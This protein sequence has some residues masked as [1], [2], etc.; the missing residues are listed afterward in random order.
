ML[1]LADNKQ[2]Q[3]M[4]PFTFKLLITLIISGGCSLITAQESEFL[5]GKVL[6]QKTGEPVVFATVRILGKAKG[7]VTNMDGS[8]RLPLTYRAAGESIQIS[9][10]GYVKKEFELQKLSPQDINII[11]LDHGVFSLTE[12]VVRAKRKRR[13]SA[14]AIVRRAIE[15]IPDNYPITKFATKG[16]YRDY[17]LDSLGYL[18]LNEA[19]LQVFDYGFNEIDSATTKIR[20]YDYDENMNFRRDTLADDSYNYKD[21]RKIIDNAYLESHG[22]NEFTILRVHD[23]IRNYRINSFDFIN[24]MQYGDVLKNHS[25]KKLT[26]TYLDGEPLYTI[27]F[28]KVIS[29]YTA[30]GILYISKNDFAI[31]KLEYAVYDDNKRDDGEALRERGIK[32]QLIFEI[33]TEYKRGTAY[34]LYL[35]YI[36]F[37]N[38]FQ[39]SVPPKFVI[40][41]LLVKVSKGA[42]VLNFNKQPVIDP[43]FETNEWYDFKYKDKKLDFEK[44]EIKND[45]SVILYPSMDQRSLHNMNRE[46]LTMSRKS[47]DISK[48]LKYKVTGLKD[49]EGNVL[50]M[51]TYRNYDQFREFFAQETENFFNMPIDSILMDKGKP[52][53]DD[54]PIIKPDDF[55]DY[56][57]NTP[58]KTIKE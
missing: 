30:R 52:I 37:H 19:L 23:A 11:R 35:N 48:V 22:G 43:R 4:R 24:S 57:M 38:T 28:K 42:L 53:F 50:N 21:W 5:R 49:V 13:L 47:Q 7:V 55:E 3:S 29:D 31:H 44:I 51:W 33:V 56:W 2:F 36:S 18:N 10:M 17:Q 45:S 40:D 25:F 16:Y 58:L 54:Q 34:Q 1:L 32:G 41:N 46:L 20:I 12:A 26:E 27:Q 6:D 15:N 9:S 8:F 39:L 14:K